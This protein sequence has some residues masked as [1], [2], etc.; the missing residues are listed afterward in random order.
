MVINNSPTGLNYL[1]KFNKDEVFLR[2]FIVALRKFLNEKIYI[3]YYLNGEEIKEYIP[4]LFNS[5]G[6]ERFLQDIF[7]SDLYD[8]NNENKKIEANIEAIPRG[9]F[10]FNSVSVIASEL[11]NRFVNGS[12]I[13]TDSTGNMEK[14]FSN[15]NIIPLNIPISI[16]I[17]TARK[18]DIFRV[19]QRLV[20]VFY[21]MAKFEFMYAGNMIGVSIG[22]P[23]DMETKNIYE[24]SFGDVTNSEITFDIATNT[25]LPVFDELYENYLANQSIIKYNVNFDNSVV[26]D[27]DMKKSFDDYTNSDI[28]NLKK[29]EVSKATSTEGLSEGE[30]LRQQILKK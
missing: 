23:E 19:W 12:R 28:E 17:L 5:G 10:T 18:I 9:V 4:F 13:V 29:S 24:F 1:A 21:A 16:Q 6:D 2:A 25:Y 3:N 26:P 22:F 20:E 11:T 15:I 14:I 27:S 7:I 30:V 8:D